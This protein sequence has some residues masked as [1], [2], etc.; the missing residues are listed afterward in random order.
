MH[1]DVNNLSNIFNPPVFEYSVPKKMV[2][3]ALQGVTFREKESPYTTIEQES[4][5]K[6]AQAVWDSV[7]DNYKHSGPK[8]AY[9]T[10]GAPGAGKTMLLHQLRD[11]TIPYIDYDD[12]SLKGMKSTYVAENDPTIK[13]Y[14]KWRPGSHYVTHVVTA[15]LWRLGYSFYFGTTSTSPFT[16]HTFQKV[17]DLGYSLKIIHL[18]APD[19]VRIKSNVKR[20]ESWVQVTPEDMIEKGNM[21]PQRINDTFLKFADEIDFY[22]RGEVDKDAQLAATWSRKGGVKVI[23]L[24]SYKQ[25][26]ELHNTQVRA[27]PKYD[28]SLLWENSVE[29]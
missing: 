24:N 5:K 6:D 15:N 17:K 8:V 14:S 21:L 13:A 27:L 11:K 1:I 3:D 2:D 28:P 25:I 23:D 4:V 22:W 19:D 10:A 7:V 20:S 12:V 29:P 18:S 16:K 9:F 26:K